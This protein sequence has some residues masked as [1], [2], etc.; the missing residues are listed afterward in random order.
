MDTR[1]LVRIDL[2]HAVDESHYVFAENENEFFDTRPCGLECTHQMQEV[3][4]RWLN[5]RRWRTHV[6][7]TTAE[8]HTKVPKVSTLTVVLARPHF[9]RSPRLRRRLLGISDLV[10]KKSLRMRLSCVLLV[11]AASQCLA[12]VRHDA[13]P[14][15]TENAAVDRLHPDMQAK[16]LQQ[17]TRPYVSSRSSPGVKR[18]KRSEPFFWETREWL[19]S[20]PPGAHET[21]GEVVRAQ[22]RLSEHARKNMLRSLRT[23]KFSMRHPAPDDAGPH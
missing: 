16:D 18:L 8:L 2:E 11:L 12:E 7:Y 21:R 19:A 5:V 17:A 23:R 9:R 1:I 20:P 10:Y 15:A 6:P 4:S 22:T 3:G 13:A 14:L